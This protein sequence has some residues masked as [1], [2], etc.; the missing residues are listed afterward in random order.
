[1][2]ITAPIDSISLAL[3]KLEV[4][5]RLSSLRRGSEEEPECSEWLWAE[6]EGFHTRGRNLTSDLEIHC[7]TKNRRVGATAGARR[8]FRVTLG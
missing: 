2:K 1:M 6:L 7:G 5:E 3:K 4:R 8:S